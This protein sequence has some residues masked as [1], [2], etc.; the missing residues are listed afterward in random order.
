AAVAARARPA[1]VPL[2]TFSN[3]TSIAAPDVFV[4]GHVPEQS[5]QRTIAYASSKG[6][7]RFAALLPNGEYGRRAGD[8]LSQ[9]VAR[10]G[11]TLVATERYDRG[12]TSI[13]SAAERLN[14][15]GAFDGV[16]IAEGVR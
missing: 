2:L 6:T 16:L 9:A 7:R 4:M 8:A 11:G 12:N 13:V 10:A 14:A 15:G 1:D 3:D 5:V